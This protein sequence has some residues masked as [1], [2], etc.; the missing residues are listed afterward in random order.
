MNE[1]DR[2]VLSGFLE[3]AKARS[4][5]ADDPTQL[6]TLDD[7]GREI[8]H[9]EASLIYRDR[10]YGGARFA[11]QELVWH[12]GRLAWGLNFY[13]VTDTAA[14]ERFFHFHKRALRQP[15]P[16]APFRGPALYIEGDL[17]YVNDWTGSLEAFRGAERV[18]EGGRQLFWLDYHGG[19]LDGD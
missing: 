13:G 14:P 8:R 7:G 4:Y 11:G 15:P 12:G 9:E 3:R 10:W 19:V 2:S 17:T 1:S 5:A 6:R 16:D 18:F